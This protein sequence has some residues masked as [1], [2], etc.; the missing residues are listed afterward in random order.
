[1]S[2]QIQ[3]G[4]TIFPYK[5]KEGTLGFPRDTTIEVEFEES[6]ILEKLNI[7]DPENN[8]FTDFIGLSLGPNLSNYDLYLVRKEQIIYKP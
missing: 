2:Y 6:E 8:E 7:R 5:S 1:M 3:L 4:T